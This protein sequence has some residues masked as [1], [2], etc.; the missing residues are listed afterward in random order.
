MIALH[1]Q[2][3]HRPSIMTTKPTSREIKLARA[4]VHPEKQIRDDTL[5]SLQE[6]L[7]T[8]TDYEELEILKLWKAL[9]YCFWLADK[10]PVQTEL[11][12]RYSQLIHHLKTNE[13]VVGYIQC[14]Y[15]IILREWSLLD[16]YRVNKFYILLRLVLR[17]S[18]K[19]YYQFHKSQ[20]N[21]SNNGTNN[22]KQS[23]KKTS[24]W[25]DIRTF[26]DIVQLEVLT[27]VPNGVRFHICDIYLQELVRITEGKLDTEEFVVA[28]QPFIDALTSNEDAVYIERV[29]KTI[30][31]KFLNEY[32]REA[33]KAH[34]KERQETKMQVDGEDQ[35][36]EEVPAKEEHAY[37]NDVNT[38]QIQKIIF[39]LASSPETN[40]RFRKRLYDL[41]RAFAAKTGVPFVTPDMLGN[42]VSSDNKLVIESANVVSVGSKRK[43][44]EEEV[45]KVV[46]EEKVG[47]KAKKQKNKTKEAEPVVEQEVSNGNGKEEQKKEEKK[48]KSFEAP[49]AVKESVKE[50]KT[51]EVK[52][53]E[54]KQEPVKAEKKSKKDKKVTIVETPV[55]S[56]PA[57][58]NTSK[59]N[60]S[61]SAPSSPAA[62]KS[63]E[64]P[65]F[66]EA[67]KFSGR[68]IGYVFKKVNASSSCFMNQ[69]LLND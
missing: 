33:L 41:H 34:E 68:R 55:S 9:Y 7:R 64:L 19:Y 17:E 28:I 37:F 2:S 38:K 8:L 39:D 23:K 12:E 14:F 16:Q 61:S 18:I 1:P 13:L 59:T 57:T 40:D 49:K 22:K 54:V 25:K 10:V 47:K 3:N 32:S 42:N 21:N 31:L 24:A 62:E 5:Q 20:S 29:Q 44:E 51:K 36:E 53:E 50:E 45:E 63:E 69:F 46:E 43:H 52:E 15:R 4:L 60:T 30:L 65:N 26:L 56:A 58:N 67:K 6:Y 66:V 35:E 27:K 11:A 48:P